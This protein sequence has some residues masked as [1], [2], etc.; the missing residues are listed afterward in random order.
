MHNRIHPVILCGGS[1]TRLWPLSRALFPKQFHKLTSAERTQFQE[2]VLR[3][4]EPASFYAPILVGSDAHQFLIGAQMRDLG[5]RPAAVVFEPCAR[6]T[7]PAIAAAALLDH[8]S[9][10]DLLLALPTDHFVADS[11]RFR[12]DIRVAARAAQDGFVVTFGL[13]PDRAETGFGY[14]QAGGAY[15]A[16]SEVR[17]ICRFVEKPGQDQA[18]AFAASTDHFWNLGMFLFQ[19]SALLAEMKAHAPRVLECAGRA[20]AKAR[21]VSPDC[22]LCEQEFEKSPG[23]SFDHAVME[24]T[25]KGAVKPVGF[26]WSDLGTWRALR[27]IAARTG[28]DD[29]GNVMFGDVAAFDSSDSFLRSDGGMVVAIGI[30]DL[31]VVASGDATLVAPLN[32]AHEAGLAVEL[33]RNQ[34]RREMRNHLLVHR[35]WGF[36]QTLAEGQNYQVKLLSINPR[37]SLSLQ[38]HKHRAERWIVIEGEAEVD[39]N[40][41]VLILRQHDS[42]EIARGDRHR[43][44]NPG[45]QALKV[46]EVQSGEYLGEDDI[47]RLD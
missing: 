14:I 3:V 41:R 45:A 24:K 34:R 9:D 30:K 11:E 28:A 26:E 33:L 23:I 44:S 20:V 21:I 27:D 43:L 19:K 8:V 38:F 22:F 12:Q 10:D 25:Q 15:R 46:I 42:V 37:A 2:T 5:V 36:F 47:V 7:A 32:R 13:K 31:L 39:L 40:G 1:G 29:A 16:N 6:G 18:S 35:P 4:A 17:E